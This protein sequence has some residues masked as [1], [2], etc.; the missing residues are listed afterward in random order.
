MFDAA[1]PLKKYIASSSDADRVFLAVRSLF[2]R[3]FLYPSSPQ[4]KVRLK[5]ADQSILEL[6]LPW[7]YAQVSDRY[8]THSYFSKIGFQKAVRD[9]FNQKTDR[10]FLKTQ[11]P[12]KRY[13]TAGMAGI[14]TTHC[15]P[16]KQVR[17]SV[18][19]GEPF[20]ESVILPYG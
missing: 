20:N 15:L 8:D 17:P 12:P 3:D 10:E 1:E 18:N 19:I 2:A 6:E 7:M 5:K 11:L 14:L 9:S 16:L 13:L 4:L